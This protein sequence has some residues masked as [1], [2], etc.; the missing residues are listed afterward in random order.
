MTPE[1]KAQLKQV[2]EKLNLSMS[3]LIKLAIET[4]AKRLGL[5]KG[6]HDESNN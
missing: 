3:E 2:A 6:K 5:T 1:E 4:E